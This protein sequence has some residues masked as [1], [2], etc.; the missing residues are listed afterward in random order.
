M[1]HS[2]FQMLIVAQLVRNPPPF[3][4]A[5]VYYRVHKRPATNSMEHSPFQML[6]V[7]QLVRNPPPFMEAKVYYRVHKRPSPV[8]ILNQIKPVHILPNYFLKIHI[9]II[10]SSIPTSSE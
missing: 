2:P 6:I 5:K 8:P 1:E 7:A 9:N 4:E 3:M 10:L